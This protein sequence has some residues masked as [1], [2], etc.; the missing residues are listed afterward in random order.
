MTDNNLPQWIAD[1]CGVGTGK[2]KIL[3]ANETAPCAVIY[4]Q[5]DDIT[6]VRFDNRII[7]WVHK[8]SRNDYSTVNAFGKRDRHDSRQAAISALFEANQ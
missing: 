4:E 1:M 5:E 6:T 3:P 7:G 8:I 2:P